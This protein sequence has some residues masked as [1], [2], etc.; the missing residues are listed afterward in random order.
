[1]TAKTCKW[2]R[3]CPRTDIHGHGYCGPHYR[4]LYRVGAIQPSR[5]D[6]GPSRDHIAAY[7]ARGGSMRPLARLSG[8]ALSGL[9]DIASG[10]TERVHKDTARKILAVPLRPTPTGCVR[11]VHAMARQG[12]NLRQISALIGCDHSALMSALHR[13][14]WTDNIA[15]PLARSYDRFPADRPGPSPHAAKLAAARGWVPGAAWEYLDIDDPK[16]KPRGARTP[17]VP[18]PSSGIC[19]L[20]GGKFEPIRIT[21]VY[22]SREHYRAAHN[23][24]K[25]AQQA[26]RRAAARTGQVAA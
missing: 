24:S 12:Y 15:W 16:S 10:A 7:I 13:N 19:G 23:A 14:V 5:I 4:K 11:R 6:A 1:M 18:R 22:C 20:C 21:D 26:A 25:R 9:S 3:G 8:V 17:S 2:R